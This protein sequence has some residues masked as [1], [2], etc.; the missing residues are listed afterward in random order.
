MSNVQNDRLTPQMEEF[1]RCIVEHPSWPIVKCYTETYENQNLC[2][3]SA[4]CRASTLYNTPKIQNRVQELYQLINERIA[5]ESVEHARLLV[6]RMRNP[7][8]DNSDLVKLS[9]AY[10][11]LMG[12]GTPTIGIT[13]EQTVIQFVGD[14]EDS[15]AT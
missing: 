8:I 15:E 12:R 4:Y 5:F 6:D 9:K 1:C 13:S 3:S 11:E 2:K 10:L 7:E 14:D